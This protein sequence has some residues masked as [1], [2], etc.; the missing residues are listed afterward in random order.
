MSARKP[1]ERKM[2]FR[3][4]AMADVVT[5]IL[6]KKANKMERNLQEVYITTKGAFI[7]WLITDRPFIGGF[8]NMQPRLSMGIS[9]SSHESLQ[10]PSLDKRPMRTS[11]PMM[12]FNTRCNF[13]MTI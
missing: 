5:N 8:S 11:Q 3:E 6:R 10:L 7:V 13:G 4:E 1:T 12:I 2:L 9:T